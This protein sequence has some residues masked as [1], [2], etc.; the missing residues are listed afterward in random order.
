MKHQT[1]TPPIVLRTDFRAHTDIAAVAQLHDTIYREEFEF[2]GELFT[3][4]VEDS[5][6]EFAQQYQPHKDALWMYEHEGK[7]IGCIFLMNRGDAAQLRYF[8]IHRD[9]RGLGFGK[10]LME[11]FLKTLRQ[12]HYR[13]CYLWTV[14]GLTQAAHLYQKYGFRV[15]EERLSNNFGITLLE[16]RYELILPI[17]RL[18]ELADASGL[19]DLT[20]KTFVDTYAD[21]NTAENM[22]LHISTRFG[23]AQLQHEL[24]DPHIQYVIV[25]LKEQLV[26]FVKLVKEHS[27][28]ELSSLKAVEIERFYV[29]LA[30]QGKSIGTRLMD[31]ALQWARKE[32]F[33]VAWLGVWEHNTKALQFYEKMGFVPF[34]EHIFTF[35]TEL[36]NDFL[37]KR[38]LTK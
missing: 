1:A 21:F 4:Y 24:L 19:R 26:G 38:E 30:Y 33:E 37:L 31:Y 32:G 28:P 29:D 17:F 23:L 27:L 36:Q 14:E 11:M 18:G 2:G 3:K 35:G 22:H 16:Q 25:E 8:L 20:E 10:K 7:L 6:R 34:G 12:R 13:S 15:T 9:F 5:L